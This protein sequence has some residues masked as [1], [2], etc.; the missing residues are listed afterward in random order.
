MMNNNM[1]ALSKFKGYTFC[2]DS[3]EQLG[4]MLAYNLKWYI[5]ENRH[6]DL[7]Y[8]YVPRANYFMEQTHGDKVLPYP[9]YQARILGLESKNIRHSD[10]LNATI[11]GHKHSVYMP[12]SFNGS[13]DTFDIIHLKTRKKQHAAN[14]TFERL[15]K[16]EYEEKK[17]AQKHQKSISRSILSILS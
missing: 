3:D 1:I 16:E 2:L 11:V 15:I 6:A 9:D 7:I 14:A 12:A 5:N 17:A 8:Y 13:F 4:P 10:H